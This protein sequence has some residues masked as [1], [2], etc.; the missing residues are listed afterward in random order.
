MYLATCKKI[1]EREPWN[2]LVSNI[3]NGFR[4]KIFLRCNV[5]DRMR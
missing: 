1:M 5:I 2:G 3:N 4:E